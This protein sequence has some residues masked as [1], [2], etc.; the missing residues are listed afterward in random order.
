M[1]F[2]AVYEYQQYDDNALHNLTP[3]LRNI[4]NGQKII[5]YSH[6][7]GARYGSDISALSAGNGGS[8]DDDGRYGLCIVAGT[9]IQEAGTRVSH[10]E[11]TGDSRYD[12][13][14]QIYGKCHPSCVYSR[15][16]GRL[17]VGAHGIYLPSIG[18]IPQKH[19]GHGCHDSPYDHNT[20][21]DAYEALASDGL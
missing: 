4:D 3:C 19:N 1:L 15:K 2:P 16:P 17:L 18:S 12:R 21:E 6:D 9:H 20:G 8:P 7:N 13:G 5:Q 11:E 14:Y 10:Q